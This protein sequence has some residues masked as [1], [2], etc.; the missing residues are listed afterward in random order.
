MKS[1]LTRVAD[2]PRPDLG[3]TIARNLLTPERGFLEADEIGFLPP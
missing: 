1:Y 3:S 2:C